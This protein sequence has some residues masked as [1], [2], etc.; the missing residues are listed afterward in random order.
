MLES[1]DTYLVKQYLAELKRELVIRSVLGARL[2]HVMAEVADHLAEAMEAAV[3]DSEEEVVRV[4]R[5]FGDP[6]RMATQLSAAYEQP[7]SKRRFLWPLAFLIVAFVVFVSRV[8]SFALFTAKPGSGDPNGFVILGHRFLGNGIWSGTLFL[9]FCAVAFAWFGFRSRRPLLGQ[10][11][12]GAALLIAGQTIWY[13]ATSYPV[14]AGARRQVE[15]YEPV[16]RGQIDRHIATLESDIAREQEIGRLLVAGRTVYTTQGSPTA[17]P[18]SLKVG[19]GYL[20]PEGLRE[21]MGGLRPD[22]LHPSLRPSSWKEAVTAWTDRPYETGATFADEAIARVP[23]DIE[24]VQL[25]IDQANWV[26]TQPLSVQIALDLRM[27]GLRT[28]AIS[29]MAM[30]ASWGGWLLWLLSRTFER[31][32]RRLMVRQMTP[33]G[34]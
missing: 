23:R 26:R 18:A 12:A 3:P 16:P 34:A 28:A 29:G 9:F 7:E 10:F 32:R 2:E 21:V 17:V 31:L 25:Q 6:K 22:E 15:W 13:A 5:Q 33:E 8:F 30:A 20:T 14:G 11:V 27:V 24:F 4:I 19:A 1:I